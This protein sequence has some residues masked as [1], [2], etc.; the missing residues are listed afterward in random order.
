MP[1]FIFTNTDKSLLMR[2]ARLLLEQAKTLE[3]SYGLNW[4]ADP[5]HRAAK[6]EFDRLHRDA[7]DLRAL[8]HRYESVTGPLTKK[9]APGVRRGAQ[10]NANEAGGTPALPTDSQTPGGAH[11]DSND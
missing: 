2:A 6:L 8:A 11:A 5:E 7:R 9:R 10:A 1:E 3:K 4:A